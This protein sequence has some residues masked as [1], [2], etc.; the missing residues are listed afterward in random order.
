MPLSI[1]VAVANR[2]SRGYRLAE[3]LTADGH[4]V[5]RADHTRHAVALLANPDIDVLLLGALENAAAAPVL[6]RQLR[7]GA[8][9]PRVWPDVLAI[10]LAPLSGGDPELDALRAYE[11]GSDH[12]LPAGASY[13]HLR[14]ALTVVTRRSHLASR[15]VQ[16]IGTIEI[17][18]AA[19]EVRVAGSAVALSAKEFSLLAALA[20]DPTRVFTKDEL[21]R[22]VWGLHEPHRTRTL[23]SHVARLRRKLAEQGVQAVVNVWGVG[24]RLSDPQPPVS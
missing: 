14:A 7:A 3:Q 8:L 19:R 15:R 24:Y 1:L 18:T 22:A 21:L 12:H 6:L 20:C 4:T 10:T 16:R 11:T 5:R 13:L 23:D 9:G 2:S 17:D